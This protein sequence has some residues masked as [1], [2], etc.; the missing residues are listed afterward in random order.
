MEQQRLMKEQQDQ[1]EREHAIKNQMEEQNGTNNLTNG[2]SAML[3]LNKAN[4]PTSSKSHLPLIP[5]AK[6]ETVSENLKAQ[7]LT[8]AQFTEYCKKR[9]NFKTIRVMRFKSWSAG[10]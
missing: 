2:L 3:N 8:P 7:S 10:N 4:I 6:V 5:N 1:K 9:F